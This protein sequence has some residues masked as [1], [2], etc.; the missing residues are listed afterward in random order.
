MFDVFWHIYVIFTDHNHLKRYIKVFFNIL[1]FSYKLIVSLVLLQQSLVYSSYIR[2]QDGF[3]TFDTSE[4]AEGFTRVFK[5]KQCDQVLHL[6]PTCFHNPK[7]TY[8][9]FITSE[10]KYYLK[11]LNS[12]GGLDPDNIFLYF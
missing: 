12:K 1:N 2:T 8:F 10:I 9:A 3:V 6:P 7:I 4:M 5:R 11:E